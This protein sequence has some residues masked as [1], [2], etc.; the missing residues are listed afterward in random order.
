MRSVRLLAVALALTLPLAIGLTQSRSYAQGTGIPSSIGLIYTAK[1]KCKVG[2]WVLYRITGTNQNGEKSVDY[3]KVQA[4]L[5]TRWMG[6]PCVWIETGFGTAPDS[7]DWSAALFSE[8]A[9]LD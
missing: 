2:D 5:E 3:Q 9:Y 1:K 7:L 8:N 6:E 4:V